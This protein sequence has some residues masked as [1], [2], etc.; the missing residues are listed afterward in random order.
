MFRTIARLLC[1]METC[2]QGVPTRFVTSCGLANELIEARDE[3]VLGRAMERYTGYGLLIIDELGG[4]IPFSK[5]SA[6]RIFQVLAERHERKSVIITTNL[7]FGDWSQA[8]GDSAL[9]EALSD[10]VTQ[11]AHI[12]TRTWERYRLRDTIKE[13]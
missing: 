13:G 3:K 1:G 9:T 5:E 11:K 2:G 4:Y 8:F 10:R 6:N 7:G 12:I